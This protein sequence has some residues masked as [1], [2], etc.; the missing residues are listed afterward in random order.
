MRE[1]WGMIASI[2][3]VS[4]SQRSSCSLVNEERSLKRSAPQ[5][6]ERLAHTSRRTR[7]T[8]RNAQVKDK[9][10]EYLEPTRTPF[11]NPLEDLV[12]TIHYE[13][14][15]R[16]PK[17]MRE[18]KP[19][20]PHL[21]CSYHRDHG[22]DIEDCRHLR[23]VV[24]KWSRQENSARISAP[25]HPKKKTKI[26]SRWHPLPTSHAITRMRKSPAITRKTMPWET[27]LLW[28]NSG[29]KWQGHSPRSWARQKG[30]CQ[31]WSFHYM[32]KSRPQGI[33]ATCIFKRSNVGTI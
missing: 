11:T 31:R 16:W 21:Y 13:E 12:E 7:S 29:H 33:Q 4:E 6:E 2:P 22:H 14:F 27:V 3:K 25:N 19:C 15:F 24:E 30:S 8:R 26:Y 18:G 9:Q 23:D 17:P 28:R 32:R 20:N 5:R 10:C 1:V